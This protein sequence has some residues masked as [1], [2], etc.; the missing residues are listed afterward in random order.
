MVIGLCA[1]DS[2]L[3]VPVIGILRV[4]IEFA[5]KWHSAASSA[6][7]QIKHPCSLLL[8]RGFHKVPRGRQFVFRAASVKAHSND[9]KA[10]GKIGAG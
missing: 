6:L 3:A 8:M 9:W 4:L 10:G 7:M 2:L 5:Q 1:A